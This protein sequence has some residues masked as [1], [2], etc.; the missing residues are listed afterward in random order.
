[1]EITSFPLTSLEPIISEETMYYHYEKLYKN[2]WNQF[3][4]LLGKQVSPL[5]AILRIEQ[6]PIEERGKILH[7]AGGVLNHQLYFEA[8]RLDGKKEPVG[9]LKK[10]IEQQYG[11][12]QNFKK[13]FIKNT[14]LLVGSGYTFLVFNAKQELDIVNMS[15]QETPYL[16]DMIPL[17][18]IDLWEHAYYLDYK[19]ERSSYV[20]IFFQLID[21]D[22]IEARFEKAQ[23]TKN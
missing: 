1:M 3:V 13:E 19:V 17:M 10:R 11:S 14:K 7:Y 4:A 20:D 2:Y 23:S 5:E 15:N 9:N 21:F 6:F 16:Y 22:V 12:Y 18:N 8:L